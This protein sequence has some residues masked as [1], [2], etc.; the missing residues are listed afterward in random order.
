[1][2]YFELVTN[3]LTTA[4]KHKYIEE[5][6][7]GDIYEFENLPSRRYSNFVLSVQNNTTSTDTT[8]YT[9]N[10]FVTDR[11]TDNK[12]NTLEVQSLSK[13]ILE[14]ILAECFDSL[15][16]T[17]YT[18]WTEKFNDLCAGCYVTFSVTLPK[19]LICADDSLF[20][21]AVKEINENG[22]YNV[23]EIDEVVVDIE[24][25]SC[26]LQELSD[27]IKVNHTEQSYYPQDGYDGISKMTVNVDIPE[28]SIVELNTTI[29]KNNE[30]L[31]FNPE[32][33]DADY[34][35]QANIEVAIPTESGRKETY[36]SNGTY[37][38]SPKEGTEYLDDATITVAVPDP[39]LQMKQVQLTDTKSLLVNPDEGYDGI[40]QLNI[41]QNLQQKNIT[42]N[43]SYMPDNGYNGIKEVIV[44]VPQ[45]TLEEL[46]KNITANGTNTYTSE[47]GKGFNKVT[48]TTNV[49][50]PKIEPEKT[51]TIEENDTDTYVTPS[52][53][54][55]A[56]QSV[57]VTTSIPL[58]DDLSTDVIDTNGTYEYFPDEGYTAA[59]RFEVT[60]DVPNTTQEK[61]VTYTENGTY[62]VLPDSGNVG[63]H[64]VAINVDVNPE[65]ETLDSNIVSNGTYN[66]TP[67]SYGYDKAN[68]TVNVPNQT[69]PGT[70][71]LSDSLFTETTTLTPTK[72]LA[73]SK[74]T[75][76]NDLGLTIEDK[77]SVDL[78]GVEL[79][80]TELLGISP[81]TTEGNEWIVNLQTEGQ[82]ITDT[83]ATILRGGEDSFY[84]KWNETEG[85]YHLGQVTE[86][87]LASQSPSTLNIN[88]TLGEYDYNG[89]TG[90]LE[91]TSAAY[92]PF[93]I[94]YQGAISELYFNSLRLEC[95]GETMCSLIPKKITVA[96]ATYDAIYDEISGKFIYTK[97]LTPKETLPFTICK[98]DVYDNIKEIDY[99]N[100]PIDDTILP[101]YMVGETKLQKVT[102]GKFAPTTIQMLCWNNANYLT[103]L[104]ATEIDCSKVTSANGAIG[105]KHTKLT[106]VIGDHTL[107]EVEAGKIVAFKNLGTKDLDYYQL[108]GP[109]LRYSSLLA[110]VKGLADRTDKTQQAYRI[111]QVAYNKCLNDD[112]TTPDS[113]TL[114]ARQNTLVEI[115]TNK[116]YSIEYKS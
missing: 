75:L 20:E 65:Q 114:T 44:N 18:F 7:Y 5:V 113:D 31:Y 108:E 97:V 1:M 17:T 3:I 14:Q 86:V 94:N 77:E 34:F 60:V 11:L 24:C 23:Q 27:T 109:S 32:E 29:S 19:E 30:N 91:T 59:K 103:W 8:T 6:Y 115:L 2:N 67:T 98:L 53:G 116:N 85:M 38:I 68:I 105:T 37:T 21:K 47:E 110:I 83:E 46:S 15:D 42:A 4:K 76:N 72:P 61:E 74:V 28:P 90:M 100:Y 40:K 57:K 78:G 55:D 54:Y 50:Q 13:T 33:Y 73:F 63:M 22:T 52:E 64:K 16:S 82:P 87:E 111:S 93:I 35:S 56:L 70:A 69:Q 88:L 58:Q 26:N 39:K 51:V 49:P 99:N 79:N 45:T 95:N 96:N 112:G 62:E 102:L 41:N 81:D 48:I 36:T 84:F 66:Y 25:K 9:F 107:E 89:E 10:A 92:D 106:T 104:D 71:N 101:R 80:L 12:S 43:G